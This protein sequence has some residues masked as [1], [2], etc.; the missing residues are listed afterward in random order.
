MT[1]PIARFGEEFLDM[2]HRIGLSPISNRPRAEREHRNVGGSD[3][4]RHL[5]EQTV[6]GG[7]VLTLEQHNDPTVDVKLTP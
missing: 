4:R 7:L 1:W 5:R 3:R 6:V 2:L